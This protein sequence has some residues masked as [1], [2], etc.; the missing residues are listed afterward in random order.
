MFKHQSN[1]VQW[2][3]KGIIPNVHYL[4]VEDEASLLKSIAWSEQHTKETQEIIGHAMRFSA[5]NLTIEDMYH[6][7]IA[8]LTVYSKKIQSQ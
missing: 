6:Y 8:V 4:S 5:N 2:F 1:H 7:W 3:Y